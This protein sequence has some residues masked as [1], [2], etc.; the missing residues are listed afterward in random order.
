MTFQ[1]GLLIIDLYMDSRVRGNNGL[2]DLYIAAHFTRNRQ[3]RKQNDKEFGFSEEFCGGGFQV[4][5]FSGSQ[6]RDARALRLLFLPENLT[7]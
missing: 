6:P 4:V 3:T 1:D 7:G 5:R 2:M